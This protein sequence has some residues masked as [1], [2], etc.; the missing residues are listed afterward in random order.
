ME[1]STEKSKVMVNSTNDKHAVIS[2]NGELLEEVNSFT[3]LGAS[4]AKDGTSTAEVLKRIAMATSAMARLATLWKTDSIGFAVKYKMYK[5]LVVSILLYGCE[6]W[7]LLAETERRIQTFEN[8]CLRKLLRITYMEHKTNEYVHN[9]IKIL[10]GPQETL[11]T[12]VKRRKLQ[13]F[14][15]VTRHDTLSKTILQGTLEG[16]RRRG[17]P[18]KS[19]TDNSTN[20]LALSFKGCLCQVPPTTELVEGL[21]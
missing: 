13:W 18:R 6:T 5:V 20:H 3:Y 21:K 16:G 2:M 1:V 11:L 12:T 9:K 10:V 14:G 7:T 15:H 4:L 17:R 19:W 8:K